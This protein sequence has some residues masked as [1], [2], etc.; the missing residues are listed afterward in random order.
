MTA[1]IDLGHGYA[2]EVSDPD[3][4]GS[5]ALRR[6]EATVTAAEQVHAALIDCLREVKELSGPLPHTYMRVDKAMQLGAYLVPYDLDVYL[7][8]PPGKRFHPVG[9]CGSECPR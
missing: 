7:H 2:L 9:E 6:G 1:E 3:D 5:H 4:G 8:F